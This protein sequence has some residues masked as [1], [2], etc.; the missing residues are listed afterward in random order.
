MSLA[1][2]VAAATGCEVAALTPI[3]GGDLNDAY[4]AEFA[5]GRFAFVKTRAGATRD[6]YE[7]EAAGLSWLARP[8]ALAVPEVLA[9]GDPFLVLEWVEPGGPI[10]YALLGHGLALLHKSGADAHGAPPPGAP[11][12]ELR[13][14]PLVLPAATGDNWPA[15]YAEHRLEPLVGRASD[16]GSLDAKGAAAVERVCARIDDLAGPGEPP[17]LLHG[18]LWSGN[19]MSGPEGPVLIDP[20]AYGGHREVDLAMLQLFGSPPAAFFSAYED[21]HPLAA[22]FEQRVGLWQ[23]FPLLVHTV[24]FGGGYGSQV[25]QVAARYA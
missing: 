1:D 14:G 23:L 18:D 10:D 25:A 21:F 15:F 9:V 24:L 4:R 11:S 8:S 5:D 17:A 7:I 19:V 2:D 3:S 22:G 16:K 20:A 13:L 6:E 12:G